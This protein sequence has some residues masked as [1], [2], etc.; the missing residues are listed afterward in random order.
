MSGYIVKRRSTILRTQYL[1][2]DVLAE[3]AVPPDL[4]EVLKKQG[5]IADI[6]ANG[7][8]GTAT[9]AAQEPLTAPKML[10]PISTKEGTLEL[11]MATESV[12]NALTII[13]KTADEIVNALKGIDAQDDILILLDAIDSR[14]T[15]KAAIH[16][17]VKGQ[18]EDKLSGDGQ[19]EKE[20]SG[21][22]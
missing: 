17:K 2:G 19:S 18:S 22:A 16:A 20:G 10:I 8:D 6:N 7:T 21:D 12:V 14:K 4:V 15:V 13:Q 9:V 3:D 5:Y 1:P 11:K